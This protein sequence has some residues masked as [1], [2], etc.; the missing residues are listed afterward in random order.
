MRVS[1]ELHADRLN[2]VETEVSSIRQDVG[3]LKQGFTS[4]KADVR[5]LSGILERI[6]HGVSAAQQ[7]WQED[8]KDSRVNPLALASVLITIISILVG[9]AWTIGGSL[10]RQDERSTHLQR[11]AEQIE[12]QTARSDE[13]LWR[14]RAA[15]GDGSGVTAAKDE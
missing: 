1:E 9:G 5:G 13:R 10:A 3:E 15:E 6:E 14:L 2:R 7:Q 8:K 4:V 11:S 12:R